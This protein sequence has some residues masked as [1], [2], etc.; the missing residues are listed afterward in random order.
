MA[1][2]QQSL[3]KKAKLAANQETWKVSKSSAEKHRKSVDAPVAPDPSSGISKQLERAKNYQAALAVNQGIVSQLLFAISTEEDIRGGTGNGTFCK[4]SVSKPGIP[5]TGAGCI[6]DPQMGPSE[7]KD[8]CPKCRGGIMTCPGHPGYIELAAPIYHPAF[9]SSVLIILKLFCYTHWKKS[10]EER[11]N[12]IIDQSLRERKRLRDE[13]VDQTKISMMTREIREKL[14]D[15]PDCPPVHLIPC[16]NP[17]NIQRDWAGIH[18]TAKLKVIEATRQCTKCVSDANPVTYAIVK[19]YFIE[20]KLGEVSV[21][22]DPEDVKEFLTAI[23]ED[24]TTEGVNKNWASLLG[25]GTNKLR[26]LVM[27]VFPVLSNIHRHQ[28]MIAGTLTPHAFTN[29]YKAILEENIKLLEKIDKSEGDY[30]SK[31]SR[32]DIAMGSSESDTSER[33]AGGASLHTLCENI[34]NLIFAKDDKTDN[35]FDTEHHG[36]RVVVSVQTSINGKYGIIRHDVAGK[37]S[38]HSGRAVLIGDPE[39]MVDEV[40]ISEIFAESVTIP[41]E[42]LS[43]EDITDWSIHMPKMVN[44]KLKIGLIKKVIK[45]NDRVLDLEHHENVFLEIGDTVRRSIVEGDILVITRQPVLHKG[46]IQGFRARIFAGGGNVIRIH[47]SVTGPFNA[48]FDGD[49]MNMAVPQNLASRRDVASKMMVANCARGDQYSSPW[50]GLIQNSI[51]AA[52]LMTAKSTIISPSLRDAIIMEGLS[53]F[54]KRNPG[55]KFR[56][57]PSAF[58]QTLYSLER[59]LDPASGRAVLSFFFPI[60]FHY[61]RKAKGGET[62]LVEKGFLVSGQ[63]DKNDVGKESG[64]MVDA[65]LEQYDAE[66]VVVFLSAF[67][68]G[69]YKYIEVTG[70]TLGPS[71]CVL[72]TDDPR[73]DPQG[74][75]DDLIEAAKESAKKLLSP[76]TT[77]ELAKL[78]LAGVDKVMAELGD[79]VN[80]IVKS[81]GVD[82]VAKKKELAAESGD[83]ELQDILATALRILAETKQE[84]DFTSEAASHLIKYANMKPNPDSFAEL[85]RTVITSILT[86][87]RQGKLEERLLVETQIFKILIKLL[88]ATPTESFQHEE[89]NS[90]Y[91]SLKFMMS[92]PAAIKEAMQKRLQ[93]GISLRDKIDGADRFSNSFLFIVYSGAK[94]T[95]NNV[96]QVLGLVGP[97]ERELLDRNPVTNRTL[98]FVERDDTDPVSNGF[99]ASPFGTGLN[100]IEFWHHAQASRGNI[101]ESNLKP[102]DTGYFYRR[103]WIMMGD[104]AA[105]EDGS[106]RNESG[107]I[108]Q[109]AYGGDM[110]DPRRLINVQGDPQFIHASMAVKQIRSAAGKAEFTT[111]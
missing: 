41:E 66:T 36:G 24:V 83:K 46:G 102:K 85:V 99:C 26:A 84:I 95:A 81:G 69:L 33:V 78:A 19:D 70:F 92:E 111:K 55:G 106:A 5:M 25:F 44:G 108:I 45:S 51:V 4:V 64:G 29:H 65:I 9:I 76:G 31:R 97:Q 39:I 49:E 91:V 58:L 98:P 74:T 110:F 73:D 80:A 75:I 100:P 10:R 8:I 30:M 21:L 62:V 37:G 34:Y 38:D 67:T 105:Y 82:I 7:L 61:E 47:P 96:T 60:D 32:F 59:N 54:E 6:L 12:W 103:A 28:K 56:T 43:Q 35:H 14:L 2:R 53:I 52:K 18:G 50:I 86:G 94:G 93:E 77:G 63:L 87:K 22:L 42:I 11:E 20:Q 68:S 16:F 89:E 109:F 101:I 107:R 88:Q 79:R 23:D 104:I 15:D 48:D 90:S 17:L 1:V 40:G 27:N 71:D 57:N 3:L 13:R 72:D